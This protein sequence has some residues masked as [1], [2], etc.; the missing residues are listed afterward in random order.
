M[1]Q[2]SALFGACLVT[3]LA[4][5]ISVMAQDV[6]LTLSEDDVRSS[7]RKP[8]YSPYAGRSFPTEV[9]WGDTHVHTNNSLDA[10]G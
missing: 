9:F 4:L 1:K 3:A 10:R 5:P 6:G 2:R 8:S 7:I